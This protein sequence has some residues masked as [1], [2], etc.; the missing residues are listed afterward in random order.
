MLRA[1]GAEVIDADEVYQ[2]L[3]QPGA[4]LL[5]AIAQRFGKEILSDNGE[6]NRGRLAKIVF[7]DAS[8]LEDLEH[9]THPAIVAEIRRQIEWS[10]SPVIVVE[11]IK[12]IPSGLAEAMDQLWLTAAPS[13]IRFERLRRRNGIDSETARSRISLGDEPLPAHVQPDVI[14]DTGGDLAATGRNVAT[15]WHTLLNSNTKKQHASARGSREV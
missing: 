6:L 7:T 9:L 10:T 8:A 12:L 15:A 11:A 13:E 2:C 14:I 5:A 4:P 1:L 3:V